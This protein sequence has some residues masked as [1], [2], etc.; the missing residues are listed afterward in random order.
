[1]RSHFLLGTLALTTCLTRQAIVVAPSPI[2][3][4]DTVARAAFAGSAL[5]LLERVARDDSLEPW[6]TTGAG[7]ECFGSGN[8][9]MC[10]FVQDSV[11][12]IEFTQGGVRSFSE[13][14]ERIRRNVLQRFRDEFGE[15]R[16]RECTSHGSIC[17]RLAQIDSA[18]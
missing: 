10:G 16:V 4:A 1:M 2:V 6:I 3:R 15:L 13:R 17:P 8:F 5:N 14:N 11:L 18:P 7:P 12:K 9:H